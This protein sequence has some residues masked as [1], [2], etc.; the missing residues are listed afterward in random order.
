MTQD[1][2]LPPPFLQW[3]AGQHELSREAVCTIGR[4]PDNDIALT[5]PLAS[6]RHAEVHHGDG[7][8][9]LNDRNSTNGTY[10]NGRR[11]YEAELLH[12]GDEI[13]IGSMTYTFVDPG[14]TLH[15][16]AIPQIVYERRTGDLWVNRQVLE[17]SPKEQR[18]FD[19]LY[20]HA[21]TP[22]SKDAIAAA[23]WPEYQAA[24]YDYQ[25]ESLVKRLREKIEDDP[26]NPT[27][28]LTVRGRGY[29]LNLG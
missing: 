6:R 25:I 23:V 24:V 11:L 27:I 9:L 20:Q 13:S 14:A 12:D 2:A 1:N 17:L 15:A 16:G 22:Q 5:D 8:W 7:A 19:F 4:A 28:L 3:R 29:R 10:L 18:L 26:R 21:N